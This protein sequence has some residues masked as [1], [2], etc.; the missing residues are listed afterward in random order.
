MDATDDVLPPPLEKLCEDG[1]L[2][3]R[4]R[5][6]PPAW[7]ASVVLDDDL[8]SGIGR[9]SEWQYA[10]DLIRRDEGQRHGLAGAVTN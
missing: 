4:Y 9:E 2:G 10:V 8:L 1:G 6:N 5:N 3:L 7:T